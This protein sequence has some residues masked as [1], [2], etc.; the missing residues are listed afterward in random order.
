MKPIHYVQTALKSD[1]AEVSRAQMLLCGIA[2]G[3]PLALGLVFDQMSFAIYSSLVAYLLTVYDHVGSLRHRL[4]V[5]TLTFAMFVGL[6]GA[7]LYLQHMPMAFMLILGV[8]T[9]WVGLMGGEGSEFERALI[10]SIILMI[11]STYSTYLGPDKI[12]P[13]MSYLLAGFAFIAAALV[14]HTRIWGYEKTE[15]PSLL[16]TIQKSFSNRIEL[17]VHAIS[18]ALTALFAAGLMDYLHVERGYW[19]T[20]T[21]LLIM[22]PDRTQSVYRS[23]QRLIGTSAGALLSTALIYFLHA[24]LPAALLVMGCACF[25]PW[26]LKRNYWLVSFLITIIV[27]LLLELPIIHHGDFHTPLVRLRAIAYGS[28]L[29]VLGV[30]VSKVL[31]VLVRSRGKN[32]EALQIS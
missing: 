1:T 2:T 23:F 3:F 28:A 5:T 25:V 32:R 31:D 15:A 4:V 13:V 20:V 21:V 29:S 16:G 19:T 24:P 8:L 11:V 22:K 6:F 7:G 10:F 27:I 30:A 26:A 12:L 14:L 17:H 9:Y 18:Y